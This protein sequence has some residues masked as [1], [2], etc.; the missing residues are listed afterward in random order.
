[1]AVL[2]PEPAR[3]CLRSC[4]EQRRRAC[5]FP[6]S[7]L[8]PGC[9]GGWHCPALRHRSRAELRVIPATV[10]QDLGFVAL[11]NGNIFR[12][13]SIPSRCGRCASGTCG[14]PPAYRD[15]PNSAGYNSRGKGESRR[16]R[17]GGGTLLR[18]DTARVPIILARN[19]PP[20]KHARVSVT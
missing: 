14:V 12:H 13:A 18:T 1:M 20:R 4:A 16:G 9:L 3:G 10:E 2:D 8:P 7:T 19:P 15:T 5:A 6:P 11:R 17:G